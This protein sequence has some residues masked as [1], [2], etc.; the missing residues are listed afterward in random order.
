VKY[1]FVSDLH[2]ALKQLDWVH[3]VAQNLDLVI[4]GGDLLDI[5]APVDAR[6]QIPVIL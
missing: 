1:L 2:Y 5:A 4:I 3:P 6:A